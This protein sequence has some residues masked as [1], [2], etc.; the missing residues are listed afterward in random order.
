MTPLLLGTALVAL[1]GCFLLPGDEAAREAATQAESR[2][3]SGDLPGAADDYDAAAAAHPGQ[4]DVATGAAFMA[5]QR[6]NAEAADRFLADAEAEAGERLPE[7]KLRRA[8]VALEVGE[9]EQVKAHG[10]ASGLP[11]G[12]LLAAEVALAD[13]ER[14]E[15][16]GLLQPA[17]GAGGE[18]GRT[19]DA[20]LAL[21]GAE[22]PLVAGM[23]EAQALWALGLRKVAVK[24]VEEVALNLP[25]TF[26]GRD[27]QLLLWA[28][29]AATSGETQVARSLLDALIFPPE[30]QQW[31]KLATQGLVACA[32]GDGDTCVR[33]LA[34]LEGT[35]PADGLADARATGAMLIGPTDPDAARKL[36][37]PYVSNAAA[38]ALLE[39]GD[40]SAARESSPGGVLDSYL[41]AGG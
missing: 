12:Q 37:G 24:S 31:R 11:L 28:G 32:E 16:Q 6:G 1:S 25:D 39:A 13:G 14:E 27:E 8:L 30:G 2:L 5:L 29:R 7:V 17:S 23:S 19:A 15:A 4:V 9:L 22:D 20:Y 35:A 33:T 26:A 40:V 18:V 3:K 38:R 41:G 34:S 21:L 10:L 36:A